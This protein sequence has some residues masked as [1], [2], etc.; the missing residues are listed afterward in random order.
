MHSLFFFDRRA[1]IVR[2]RRY[3]SINCFEQLPVHPND[4]LSEDA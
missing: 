4:T 2:V 1:H 3:M